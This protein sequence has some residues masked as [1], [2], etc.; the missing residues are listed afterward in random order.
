MIKFTIEIK[1]NTSQTWVDNETGDLVL[2]VNGQKIHV[3]FIIAVDLLQFQNHRLARW[4]DNNREGYWA[5]LWK[6]WTK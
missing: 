1:E 2:E 5:K 4:E 6:Y 3:P